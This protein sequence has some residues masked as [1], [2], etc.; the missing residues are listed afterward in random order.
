MLNNKKDELLNINTATAIIELCETNRLRKYNGRYYNSEE[1]V[2]TIEKNR[3]I[4]VNKKY[5]DGI[6]E[7]IEKNGYKLF[8]N[9]FL[10]ISVAASSE[11]IQNDIMRCKQSSTYDE[12]INILSK[13]IA[14][15]PDAIQID[16]AK[17]T[18]EELTKA[19]EFEKTQ[20]LKGLVK[21]NGYWVTPEQKEKEE[22]FEYITKT[23]GKD[24]KVFASNRDALNEKN[25]FN[26]TEA[27]CMEKRRLELELFAEYGMAGAKQPGPPVTFHVAK[28][29][30]DTRIGGYIVYYERLGS[31]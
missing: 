13:S 17:R 12:A 11:S 8:N 22:I 31:W 30:T 21:Y 2:K 27:I 28:L 1:I 5:S 20:S 18:V 15:H 16:L 9:A 26:E 4:L 7:Y 23:Y 14:E 25:E 10:P 29:A 24:A 3:K 19:S 6:L